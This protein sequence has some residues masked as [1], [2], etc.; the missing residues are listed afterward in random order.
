MITV[1]KHF[2]INPLTVFLFAFSSAFH[3][4]PVFFMAY[5]VM[6]LHE[7]AHAVAAA[8]IGLKIDCVVLQPF[9]LSLRL[10][11]K[12]VSGMAE[13]IILYLSGPMVNALASFSAVVVYHYYK[14]DNLRLFYMI[15][16]TLFVVNL[17]PVMPLDGGH[18]AM[19]IIRAVFG[20]KKGTAISNILS[21]II[22]C[23]MT[24]FGIYAVI[25]C[26]NYTFLILCSLLWGNLFLLSKQYNRD[27]LDETAKKLIKTG[28]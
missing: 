26:R 19:R 27:Y 23:I 24:A 16:M 1:T 4:P 15:N 5:G 2:K 8:V 9:G 18:I 28:M 14:S 22:C 3:Y 12:M 10:K 7:I 17:L 25:L 6:I 20:I 13:E 11:N 21:L